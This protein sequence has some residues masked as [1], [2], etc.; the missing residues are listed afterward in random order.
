MKSLEKELEQQKEENTTM[1]LKC[2]TM[3][4]TIENLRKEIA[5]NQKKTAERRKVRVV[6]D[7]NARRIH[8]QLEKLP[9]QSTTYTEKLTLDDMLEWAQ[10]TDPEITQDDIYVLQVGTNDLKNKSHTAVTA[11]NL[12]K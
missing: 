7:S 11:G 12:L 2:R 4:T 1:V 5:D 8:E 9:N 10:G 3:E 6:G